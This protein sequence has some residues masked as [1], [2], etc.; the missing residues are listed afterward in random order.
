[1]NRDLLVR[2]E[3]PVCAVPLATIGLLEIAGGSRLL[4]LGGSTCDVVAGV[5]WT[6]SG[7]PERL[8]DAFKTMVAFRS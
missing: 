6:S 2:V 3:P 1:M 5:A 4:M 7:V 8:R